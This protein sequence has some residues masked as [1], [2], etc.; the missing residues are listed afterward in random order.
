MKTRNT[1]LALAVT[2]LLSAGSAQACMFGAPSGQGCRSP[3]QGASA[4]PTQEDRLVSPRRCDFD[5]E[6]L[7]NTVSHM[8]AGGVEMAMR[9][10]RAVAEEV[11]RQTMLADD[12]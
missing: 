7:I 8:A 5:K 10:M 11:G 2:G 9:V 4:C 3:S 12:I 1:L 6:E